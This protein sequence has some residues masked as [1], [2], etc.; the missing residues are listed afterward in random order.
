MKDRDDL[1]VERRCPDRQVSVTR[2][3]HVLHSS[4]AAIVRSAKSLERKPLL[5]AEALVVRC[6]RP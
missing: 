4:A 2:N 5:F 1:R 3:H 6:I